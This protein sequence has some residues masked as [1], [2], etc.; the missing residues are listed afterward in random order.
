ML[1]L[2]KFTSPCRSSSK[3]VCDV[4][5]KT[6]TK[7][8]KKGAVVTISNHPDPTKR[9]LTPTRALDS[10]KQAGWRGSQPES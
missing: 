4:E 8:T 7:R 5:P 10:L 6:K 9:S 1:I 3:K 2:V